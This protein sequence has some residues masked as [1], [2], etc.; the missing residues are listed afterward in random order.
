MLGEERERGTLHVED[1]II[2]AIGDDDAAAGKKVLD[3]SDCLVLPGFVNAHC[4]LALSALAG[5]VARGAGFADWA[6]ALVPLNFSLAMSE[7]V[8]ALRRGA[9]DLL[10][11]GVTTL[12][13]YLALPVLLEDYRRLPFRQVLFLEALG[14]QTARAKETADW[15]RKILAGFASDGRI[16][17]GIAAHACYSVSPQLFRELKRLAVEYDCPLSCHVAEFP[18]EEEFL[19]GT[20]ELYGL[21]KSLGV[22]DEGWRPPGLSPVAYLE[23]LGVLDGLLGIH[24]NQVDGDLESLTAHAVRAVFC[25][26]STRWFGRPRWLPVRDLLDRGMAVGIGTDSLASNESLNFLRELRLAAE[27]I[28]DVS[29]R[30]ILHMATLGGARALGLDVGAV[31][32]GRPADLIALR[33]TSSPKDWW[34]VPFEP[35]RSQVQA[36]MV[37]GRVVFDAASPTAV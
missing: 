15:V 23:R 12:G 28:P 22:Y 31:V 9:D 37:D 20:G 7:R 21:L 8:S 3:W 4:H 17:L 27:M 33:V 19:R 26:G 29:R 6:K 1:G 24:L 2:R 13:D 14:F 16:R 35:D 34:E 32:P 30:E 11:S 18:Q 36:V 5:R 10:G 25:P